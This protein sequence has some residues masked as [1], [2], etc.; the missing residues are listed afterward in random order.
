LTFVLSVLFFWSLYCLSFSFD[1]CTNNTKI[2][3]KGQTIQRSQEK[4]RQYKGQKKRTKIYKTL[5]RTL[6]IEQDFCI[7]FSPFSLHFNIA[8]LQRPSWP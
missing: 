1:L 3:R 7:V 4:D 8:T 6:K 5:L 2:K